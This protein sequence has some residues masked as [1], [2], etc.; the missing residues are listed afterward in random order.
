MKK[1]QK[2]KIVET[3]RANFIEKIGVITQS[4]GLPRI[5]G[6]VLAML[7][8]DGE[9][10]SFGQLADALQVSRGSI[11]SGVRM[12]ESQQLIKRV[13]KAGDRQ[14]YFLIV[15]NA[16]ANMVEASAMRARRA[17]SDIEE[18]LEDIPASETGPRLRVASYAAFYRAMEEGLRSTGE[19]LRTHR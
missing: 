7:L 17:A 13:A 3:A 16:F 19:A 6:R 10:V 11:S 18:S 15:D 4:E 1:A 9:K 14:D 8:Y 2:A 12:L 5:A